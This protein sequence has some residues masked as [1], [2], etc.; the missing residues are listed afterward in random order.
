[1]G[2]HGIVAAVVEE[3][4]DVV[5]AEYVDQ[6]LILRAILIEPR[7]LVAGRPE[8]AARRV[9]QGA[10]GGAA[11]LAGVDQVLGQGAD[12]AVPAGINFADSAAMAA[13]GFYQ[14]AGGSIDDGGHS[15]RLCVESV[16][17]IPAV[18]GA[19]NSRS[20][21][22]LSLLSLTTSPP[23]GTVARVHDLRESCE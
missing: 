14:A 17:G 10:D 20:A 1:C 23:E 3:I 11:L 19:Q 5:R 16:H 12:D 9:A 21:R 4:A 6:A 15:A 13:R 18:E 22:N 2:I 8:G 7:Q